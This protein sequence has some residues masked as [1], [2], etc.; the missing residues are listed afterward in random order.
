M[1]SN[2]R[3]LRPTQTVKRP[4]QPSRSLRVHK[5]RLITFGA[6]LVI[7]SGVGGY[8]LLSTNNAIKT[9]STAVASAKSD[10]ARAKAEKQSLKV[11]I[12]QLNNEQYLGKLVRE[13][14]LMS[15]PGEVVF[16]LP[17]VQTDT[18]NSK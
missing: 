10:L 3:P 8:Q 4:A 17:S 16:S 15:K 2:I 13:R 12:D 6:A 1:A 7:I 14:Y 18:Q 11:K 5:R 9:Q